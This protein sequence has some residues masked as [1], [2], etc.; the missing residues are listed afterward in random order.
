MGAA[1]PPAFRVQ[2][3][4]IARRGIAS[5][6]RVVWLRQFLRYRG[7]RGCIAVRADTEGCGRVHAA[8]SQT[9]AR[10]A[11]SDAGDGLAKAN[12]H[13]RNHDYVYAVQAAVEPAVAGAYNRVLAPEY[14]SEDAA[15]KHRI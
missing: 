5:H 7:Q 12:A 1:R 2:R 14:L 10:S 13:K 15:V 3:R 8:R 11:G 4:R 9:L 6:A